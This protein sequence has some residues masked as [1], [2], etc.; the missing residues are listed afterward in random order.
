M[1]RGL[2]VRCFLDAACRDKKSLTWGDVLKTF[3]FIE[4]PNLFVRS[5]IEL[6][7]PKLK[8]SFDRPFT[9]ESRA[10]EPVH[11]PCASLN[12]DPNSIDRI[13]GSH[14]DQN[15]NMFVAVQDPYTYVL[16]SQERLF[17]KLAV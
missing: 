17:L 11:E 12:L 4:V 15:R 10:A 2:S 7:P 14:P 3:R 16:H 9:S 6:I 1:K 5:F 13:L 8:A